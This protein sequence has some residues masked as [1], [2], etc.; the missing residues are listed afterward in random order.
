MVNKRDVVMGVV[1][2]GTLLLLVWWMG[3][4]F[5]EAA[6]RA[7]ASN[8]P[9]NNLLNVVWVGLLVVALANVAAARARIRRHDRDE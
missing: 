5:A 7:E 8:N 9:G 1:F 6:R 4:T 2:G 3:G